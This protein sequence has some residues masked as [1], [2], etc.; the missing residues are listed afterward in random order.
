ML[1][2]PDLAKQFQDKVAS[3][4]AFAADPQAR[5]IW[6]VQRSGYAPSN[7]GRYPILRV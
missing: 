1:D 7:A 5:L 6:L 3:D 2:H 4:A